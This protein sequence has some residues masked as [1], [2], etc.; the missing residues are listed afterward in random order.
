ML[1]SVVS[2]RIAHLETIA[3]RI[4][5]VRDSGRVAS[6][7]GWARSAG[8]ARQ[9]LTSYLD[10]YDRFLAGELPSAPEIG[11]DVAVALAREARVTL[12]WFLTGIGKLDDDEMV[13]R[14]AM[15][16]TYPSRTAVLY[17]PTNS[18]R[19]SGPA[20]G[21]VGRLRLGTNED[22]G[23]AWWTEALDRIDAAIGVSIPRLPPGHG[24]AGPH[25]PEKVLKAA[26]AEEKREP[27]QVSPIRRQR[28]PGTTTRRGR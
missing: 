2:R 11:G 5:Q 21:A 12:I 25:L 24:K 3:D 13:D 7:G 27:A 8:L 15:V 14:Y 19:W 4:R 20:I 1:T 17:N 22:P 9:Y 18:G 10:R 16:D 26:L 6:L 28:S 23:E